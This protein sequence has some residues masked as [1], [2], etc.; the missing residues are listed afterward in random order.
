MTFCKRSFSRDV[1]S[2]PER[3]PPISAPS[4]ERKRARSQASG[5]VPVET[6]LMER[7]SV[8]PEVKSYGHRESSLPRS[9]FI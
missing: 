6:K 7:I 9:F 8:A 2:L 1:Y 3:S 5:Q 4:D